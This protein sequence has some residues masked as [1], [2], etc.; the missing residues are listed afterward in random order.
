MD[1]KLDVNDVVT[2]SVGVSTKFAEFWRGMEFPT[3]IG[4]ALSFLLVL[5]CLPLAGAVLAG[6][7]PQPIFLPFRGL[8]WAWR[9]VF[10]IVSGIFFYAYFL[11]AP[12]LVGMIM[13]ALDKPLGINKAGAPAYTTVLAYA[14]APWAFGALLQFIPF[15]GW[16]VGILLAILSLVALYLGLTVGIQMDSGQAI[17]MIVISGIIAWLIFMILMVIVGL[18]LGSVLLF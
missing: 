2:K 5:A 6:L 8:V 4:P 9:P 3:N 7:I 18:G 16:I 1:V 14:Y 11:G 10:G 13:G 15:V 12:L 17:I